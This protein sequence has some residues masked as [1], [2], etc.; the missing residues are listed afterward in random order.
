M[1]SGHT[2]RLTGAEVPQTVAALSKRLTQLGYEVEPGDGMVLLVDESADG[3][4]DFE[5][6][7]HDPAEFAAEKI[8]DILEERGWVELDDTAVSAE[9][10]AEIT[11]RL[12]RLGYIE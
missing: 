8:L 4:I 3:G 1:P 11:D 10:E 12:R 5:I 7:A 9:E 2:I 6:D